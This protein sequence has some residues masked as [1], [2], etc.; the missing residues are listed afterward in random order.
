MTFWGRCHARPK[1]FLK[2]FPRQIF[3]QNQIFRLQTPFRKF[4]IPPQMR[5]F[6]FPLSMCVGVTPKG[7]DAPE[8]K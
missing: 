1:I 3:Q 2:I 5:F 8:G 7:C 4:L 6:L